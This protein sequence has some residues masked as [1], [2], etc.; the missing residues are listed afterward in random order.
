MT[1]AAFAASLRQPLPE[2]TATAAGEEVK[3]RSWLTSATRLTTRS[4]IPTEQ[5]Q[6]PAEDIAHAT[7][8]ANSHASYRGSSTTPTQL[9]QQ[10]DR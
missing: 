6:N 7:L 9:S 1:P 10:V 4:I 8:K 5:Q 2:P 3:G